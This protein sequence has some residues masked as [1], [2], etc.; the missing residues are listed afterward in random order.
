MAKNKQELM[1]DVEVTIKFVMPDFC[2]NSDIDGDPKNLESMVADT[3]S[4]DGVAEHIK[5]EEFFIVD[6][7]P[8]Y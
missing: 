5:D 3:L 6:V 1:L 7:K 2:Y 4:M 8:I